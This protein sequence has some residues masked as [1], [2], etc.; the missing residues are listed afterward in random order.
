MCVCVKTLGSRLEAIEKLKPST[1]VKWCR[2][3]A[4]MVNFLSTFCPEL[5]KLLKPIYDVTRKGKQ[6]VWAKEQQTAFEQIKS[7]LQIPPAL[8]LPAVG[9]DFICIKIPVHSLWVASYIKF[10]MASTN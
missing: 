2:S 5:Q 1:T 4:E 10:R 9:E 6:F 8:H 7:R 3:L